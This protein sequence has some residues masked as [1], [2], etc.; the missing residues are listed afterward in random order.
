MKNRLSILLVE[1]DPNIST[2]LIELLTENNYDITLAED[3][4]TALDVIEANHYDLIILDEMLPH[5]AGSEILLRIRANHKICQTPV[6]MMTSLKDYDYQ[7]SVLRYGADDYIQKPFRY[8]ILLARIETILRRSLSSGF[9]HI[10]IPDG[11]EIKTITPKEKE[12]LALVVK[13]YNN[14]KIAKELI[15]SEYTVSNHIK[16]ILS[17]LK[18]ESRTQAAIIAIKLNVL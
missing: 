4:R 17:K 18:S 15:I 7:V 8:N 10:E 14:P 13:G 11:I 3:G 5:I 12:V 6:I 16:N 9:S 1:D 2:L